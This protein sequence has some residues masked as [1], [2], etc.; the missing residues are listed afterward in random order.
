[1]RVPNSDI[2]L[3]FRNYG[4][5]LYQT[6]VSLCLLE[7]VSDLFTLAVKAKGDG[8]IATDKFSKHYGGADVDMHAYSPPTQRLKT[9]QAVQVLRG[10]GFFMSLYGYFQVD[11]EIFSGRDGHVGIAWVGD[12]SLESIA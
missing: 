9:S 6:D 1:M 4:Q 12:G 8:Y 10:I 5:L 11:I 7:G 2:T 3:T